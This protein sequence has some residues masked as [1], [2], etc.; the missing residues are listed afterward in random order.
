MRTFL[1]TYICLIAGLA[2]ILSLSN[3]QPVKAV[4]TT[5]QMVFRSNAYHDGYILESEENSGLGLTT[6]DT[7]TTFLVGDDDLDRQYVAILSFRTTGLPDNAVIT[8]AK[9]QIEQSGS[10]GNPGFGS[11]VFEV[12]ARFGSLGLE[13][14]DFEAPPS[15]M[16]TGQSTHVDQYETKLFGA[17]EF[18]YINR[19]GF[20]QIRFRLDVDDNDNSSA[21]HGIYFSGATANPAS[22]RPMLTVEYYLPANPIE[23]MAFRSIAA[24]DGFI[25]ESTE[26]SEVGLRVN[27][28]GTTFRFGDDSLDRQS[29]GILSFNTAKLPDNAVITMAMIR[30]ENPRW[31]GNPGFGSEIF[32]VKSPYFGASNALQPSDFQDP[33]FD[34]LTGGGMHAN[35]YII[36]GFGS[37][38]LQYIN[39][40]GITQIRLRISKDDNDNMS[41][42]YRVCYSGE[43]A[44]P[45]S[46]PLLLIDYY[47]P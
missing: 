42:D 6:N 8:M 20:T 1:K 44:N 26:N 28:T 36:Q 43:V 39:L 13:S 47:I 35:Q 30:V 38:E 41:P 2:M 31:V 11:P 16:L 7:D 37:G 12:R 33:A 21:D 5:Q 29:V 3:P 18:Q 24:Q 34:Q 32:E 46:K 23:R 14:T 40:Q 27:S 9:L 17:G 22:R 45:S 25:L 10:V 4:T 15:A 19:A